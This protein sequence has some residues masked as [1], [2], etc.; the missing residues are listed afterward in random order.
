MI[1]EKGEKGEKMSH[2]NDDLRLKLSWQTA[3]E[4]RTCPPTTLLYSEVI[5]DNLQRHLSFCETCRENKTMVKQERDAWQ[6]LFDSMVQFEPQPKKVKKQQGQIWILKNALGGWQ[7]NGKYFSPP[8]VLLLSY[9]SEASWKVA[10]LY[11]DE[12][13]M[14]DGDVWLD[15]KFGFAQGWNVYTVRSEDLE[16]CVGI[17]DRSSVSEVLE[18]AEK[19]FAAPV[20][21]SIIWLFRE[22][23]K[24]VGSAMASAKCSEQ[25]H[26]QDNEEF[27][28][29]IFGSVGE[30]SEK[31]TKFRVPEFATTLLDLL[32]GVIDPQAIS[33]VTASTS[34][35][36][37]VNIV[38]KNANGNIAVKTVSVVLS[39]NNWEDGDYYV[40]GKLKEVQH[41]E[42]LLVASLVQNDNVV[43]ECQVRIEKGLPY[44]DIVFSNVAEDVCE[45]ATLKFVLVKP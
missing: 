25:V 6:G 10:Q 4:H 16:K 37:P 2:Y 33:P 32:S 9:S 41:E 35:S 12:R 11:S 15:D 38:T 43:H 7:E 28:N 44:F 31:L 39:E 19:I 20:E 24:D 36:L 26:A 1:V 22:M 30:V 29:K 21:N 34:T 3:Y 23:E 8:V 27:L 42:M 13:L 14:E 45:I 5:D 40:V 17:A 18:E